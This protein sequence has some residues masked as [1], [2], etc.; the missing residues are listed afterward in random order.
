MAIAAF[1]G[2]V[3]VQLDGHIGPR[4]NRDSRLVFVADINVDI[5][6][7][8]LNVFDIGA[9]INRVFGWFFVLLLLDNDVFIL[10]ASV[11]VIMLV[12]TILP[13]HRIT[14][15]IVLHVYAAITDVI[16]DSKRRSRQTGTQRQCYRDG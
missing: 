3:P 2:V 1:Q 12:V 5:F 4:A 16:L 10:R 11:L 13:A 15:V 8:D 6:Q 7:R 9:D 14:V